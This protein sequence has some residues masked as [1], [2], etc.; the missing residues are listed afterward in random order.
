MSD[1]AKLVLDAD[2]KGLKRGE[3]DLE[4]MGR[5]AGDTAQKVDRA[6]AIKQAAFGKLARVLGPAALVGAITGAAVGFAYLTRS[7]INTADEISKAAQKIGIGT[8]ELSRLRY[9]ADLSGVSFQSLQTSVG[10]LNRN[11]VEASM[12]TGQSAQAFAQMGISVTDASGRLRTSTDIMGDVADRFST[13]EDGA[14]KTA[15]AMAIFGRAGMEMIPMLNGGRDALQELTQEAD[16][17]GVVIDAETGRKAEA[18]NDN[19][20]RLGGVFSSLATQIAADMLPALVAFTD[21]AVKASGALQGFV[22]E[23]KWGIEQVR[24]IGRGINEL[25][26]SFTSLGNAGIP[27]ANAALDAFRHRVVQMFGPLAVLLMYLRD[28]G[29]SRDGTGPMAMMAQDMML[30]GRQ[31]REVAMQSAKASAAN[32]N[33]ATSLGAVGSAG[34]AAASGLR[35]TRD[36]MADLIERYYPELTTRAQRAALAMAQTAPDSIQLGLRMRILGDRGPG[37]L[38]RELQDAMNGMDAI[39]D[40]L[41]GI[42]DMS[43]K[44]VKDVDKHARD[45]ADSFGTMADRALAALDRL[46]SGIQRGDFLGILSGIL[47]IGLQLGGLGVFGKGVAANI[48]S[49][50][51]RVPSFAGGGFTGAGARSGGVDGKGGFMAVL[52]PNETVT[53]HTKGGGRQSVV[54]IN[55][56]ALAEAF[57]DERIVSAAPAIASAGA[58]M[59][60]GQ[61]AAS[62]RRRVR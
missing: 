53:D 15:L 42:V 36:E 31:V 24:L 32:D 54:V 21:W 18:F 45:I 39:P 60:Q 7:V 11:M 34:R 10:R 55:N 50:G 20:T 8:E 41:T 16:R 14:Q 57:V 17:F 1:F 3:R 51:G 29:A 46:A 30:M 61:M 28:L 62:A 2:T 22:R 6:S 40:M 4:S 19:L 47:G 27:V 48:N 49:Q 59:A 23:V 25:T 52:H 26:G 9:A 33:F 37:E 13:M 58:S 38:S 5:T 44:V 56:S 12:G 43:G 35:E